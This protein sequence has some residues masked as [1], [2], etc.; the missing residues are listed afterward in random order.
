MKHLIRYFSLLVPALLVAQLVAAQFFVPAEKDPRYNSSFNPRYNTRISPT[1]N[2]QINPKFNMN[3]NPKYTPEL[4]PKF[5]ANLNPQFNYD[6]NPKLN[7]ALNPDYNYNLVPRYGADAGLYLFMFDKNANMTA[8]IM[9]ASPNVWLLFDDK[10]NW[11]G[12]FVFTGG[13]WNRYT[14]DGL[15]TGEYLCPDNNG[16]Y[17]YFTENGDWTGEYVH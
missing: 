1:Y 5:N 4:S 3:L 7:T 6:L 9:P 13:N 14:I 10:N 12:Y 15:W 8:V 11:K 17:N 2:S 16:G